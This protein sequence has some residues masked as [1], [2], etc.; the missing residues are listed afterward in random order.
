MLIYAMLFT[1]IAPSAF[2]QHKLADIPLISV[3]DFQA[4]RTKD[5]PFPIYINSRVY[6]RIDTV[7]QKSA[8]KFEVWIKTKV[9]LYREGSFW[10]KSA[11]KEED[12]PRLLKHEQGHFYLAHIAANKLEKELPKFTFT[13]NWQE[14]VRNKFHELNRKFGK[15]DAE[16]DQETL[17]SRNLKAQEKWD[18]WI[19]KQLE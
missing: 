15:M 12:V 8:N 6:Y 9:D 17:H 5:S 13:E 1:F 7:I 18:K 2:A 14:E 16:Y 4:T 11:V 19:R 10:D 3:G